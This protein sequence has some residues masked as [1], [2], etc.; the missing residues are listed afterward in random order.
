MSIDFNKI[1]V[2][3]LA[4]IDIEGLVDVAPKRDCYNYGTLF[5]QA[6]REECWSPE[7]QECLAFLSVICQMM[8]KAESPGDPYGPWFVIDGHRGYLPEDFTRDKLLEFHEWALAIKDAE[9]RAR[10]LDVIW[11][12]TRS[13]PAAQA[14]IDAYI[15]SALNLEHPNEWTSCHER[16]ERALRLAASLGRA[17]VGIR[18]K[19]LKAIEEM[20]TKYQGTDSSN[21][22][23]RL[24]ELLLEFKHGDAKLLGDWNAVGAQKALVDGD[25]WRAQAYFL[26]AANC[27]R[28]AGNVDAQVKMQMEA[29]ESL[30]NESKHAAD[31]RGDLLAA[32]GVLSDA[33][34]AM[35]QVKGGRPRADTLHVELL[36][37][38]E[39]ALDQMGEISTEADC[40]DLV[41]S[42]L[43]SIQG[44]SR[45]D[46][47][48]IFLS[49]L[50]RPSIDDL[51][52]KVFESA[53]QAPLQAIVGMTV[54]NGRG[55]TVAKVSSL[56]DSGGDINHSGLRYRMFKVAQ[57]ERMYY[58]QAVINPMR[59]ELN[60]AHSIMRQ[61]IFELIQYCPWLRGH[62]ESAA[63]AIV[64]GFGG[65]FLLIAHMIP[66]QFE[67]LIRQAVEGAGGVTSSMDAEGIQFEKTLNQLLEMPEAITVFGVNGVFE[68][69]D[70][71]T[72][73]LGG[74]LRNEVAHGLVDDERMFRG[75]V[76]YLWWLFFRCCF[77]ASEVML[78]ARA[79]RA[80]KVGD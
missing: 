6:S 3:T 55:K 71:L 5:N 4:S 37:L 33:V 31:V 47:I 43:A 65:D 12:R 26:T 79:Q 14:A 52:V 68:L 11:V 62:A 77:R 27:Y 9:L 34:E 18:E 2:G 67:A 38:Q 42:A 25:N 16:L 45:R 21:L 36:A 60:A 78:R 29:A 19:P 51:K 40:T 54:A 30:V 41:N 32:A 73:N 56:E 50:K 17:N 48:T 63:K 8:L 76:L 39:K 69:Q 49:C 46:A 61:D 66:P 70:L 74:N 23:R 58:A 44:K 22:T 64:A 72:D 75:D 1:L 80:E 20:V 35:R 15:G 24:S 53:Q 28:A 10:L 13:F 57:H 7:Q 59:I